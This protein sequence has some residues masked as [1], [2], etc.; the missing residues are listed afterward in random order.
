MS[1]MG[2]GRDLR[3]HRVR[4]PPQT[5]V[6]NR[7]W[8]VRYPEVMSDEQPTAHDPWAALRVPQ[9]S[10]GRYVEE[11]ALRQLTTRQLLRSIV[12]GDGKRWLLSQVPLASEVADDENKYVGFTT[13]NPLSKSKAYRRR[14]GL[15]EVQTQRW[16]LVIGA[17]RISNLVF[18]S[19]FVLIPLLAGLILHFV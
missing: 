13:S 14:A 10:A 15:Q 17:R 8:K 18:W 5:L 4:P 3:Y 7:S 12:F 6:P 1:Q 2:E 11:N 19:P 16:P 9:E